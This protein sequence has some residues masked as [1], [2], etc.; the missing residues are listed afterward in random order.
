MVVMSPKTEQ[1]AEERLRLLSLWAEADCGVPEPSYTLL[2]LSLRP[3]WG[4]HS[5][6][7]ES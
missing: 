1:E 7:S 5:R 4:P 6:L 3:S 2:K